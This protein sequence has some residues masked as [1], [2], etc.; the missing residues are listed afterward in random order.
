MSF[1]GDVLGQFIVDV[2][3]YIVEA[4]ISIVEMIVQLIMILLGWD[5]GSTQIIEYFEVRNSHSKTS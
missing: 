5:S 4:V 3:V 1:V 2:I